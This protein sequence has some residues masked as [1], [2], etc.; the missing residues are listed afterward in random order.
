MLGYFWKTPE[1]KPSKDDISVSVAESV[2]AGAVGNS[3]CAEPGAS[4]YFKGA[5]TA[6]SIASKKEILGIDTKYA[7]ETNHANPFTTLEMAKAVCKMFK[8]R[9]GIATTGYSLP[10]HR[11]ENKEKNECALDIKKPYAYICLYDSLT[12]EEIIVR[13]DFDY[14]E[15]GN[16]A[17]QRATVQAK[18]AIKATQ[19]YQEKVKKIKEIAN[20]T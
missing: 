8:S 14:D 10:Y 3:L 11:E 15:N 4:N 1:V 9:F 5:I 16:R 7:E 13:E 18:V 17:T 19:M 2:T 20:T 12:N 6:Y